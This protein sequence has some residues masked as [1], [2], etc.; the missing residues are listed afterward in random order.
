MIEFGID[1]LNPRPLVILFL[2]AYRFYFWL[3]LLHLNIVFFLLIHFFL[4]GLS[5]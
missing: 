1:N 5:M 3:R 2:F 4:G